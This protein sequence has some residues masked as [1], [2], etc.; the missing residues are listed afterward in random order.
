MRVLITLLLLTAPSFAFAQAWTPPFCTGANMALQYDDK[1][2]VCA[3]MSGAQ[4][5]IGPQGAQGPAG[6]VGPAGPPGTSGSMPAQPPA[7][8]CITSH[9]DGTKW[10]CVPT[11]Y[12]TTKD[13]PVGRK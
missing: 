5:P 9:W 13:A 1:G 10:A 3:T 11:E 7:T 6:P 12:L 4:G 8:Q 2:W